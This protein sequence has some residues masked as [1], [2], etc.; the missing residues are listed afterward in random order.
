MSGNNGQV[1]RGVI[2]KAVAV[3]EAFRLDRRELSLNQVAQITGLPL[4]TAYRTAGELVEGGILE[5]VE[6]GG[7]RIGVRVFELGSIAQRATSMLS[8]AVPFMQ[9]LYEVTH[10][11]VQLAILDGQEALYIERIYGGR[12]PLMR[13]VRGGRLPL[14]CTGVGKVLLAHAPPELVER[15]LAQ[16]LKQYTPHTL[17]DARELNRALAEIRRSGVG[18]QRQEITVG[19]ASVAAPLRD[20]RGA[21]VAGLSVVMRAAPSRL[22]QLAPAVQTAAASASREMSERGVHGASAESMLQMIGDWS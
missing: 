19:L 16:G 21:V 3:L 20:E 6:T 4:S 2:K 12:S 5:R 14:H 11:T 10:E 7:Y 8:V 17:T 1:G 18:F 22:R 9:D 13:S 15:L